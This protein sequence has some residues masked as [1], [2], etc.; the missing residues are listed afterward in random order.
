[1]IDWITDEIAIGTRADAE[2]RATFK[3]GVFRSVLSLDGPLQ[4][5]DSVPAVRGRSYPLIDGPGNDA[6][7]FLRAVNAVAKL[8]A[9]DAPLLVHCHAGRSRSP[10]VVA[11]HFLRTRGI[12]PEEALALVRKKRDIAI[13]AG[14]ERLLWTL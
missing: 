4:I 3:A 8:L 5:A 11:G 9:T 2:D 13:T 7:L 6:R 14:L 12:G 10:I 1:M